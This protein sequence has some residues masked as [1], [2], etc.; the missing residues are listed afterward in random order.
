VQSIIDMTLFLIV[1]SAYIVH[2]SVGH[3]SN[4]HETPQHTQTQA[5]SGDTSTE[6]GSMMSFLR[7]LTRRKTRQ[8]TNFTM[9]VKSRTKFL[10]D[11]QKNKILFQSICSIHSW[12]NK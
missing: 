9:D 12:I 4:V 8:E 10:K 6:S 7:Q 1:N 3:S 11:N 5:C 2:R